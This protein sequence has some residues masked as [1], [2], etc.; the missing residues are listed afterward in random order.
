MTPNLT[1]PDADAI[2]HIAF[3]QFVTL[4]DPDAVVAHLRE[5][6]QPL[7]GSILVAAE[8]ING[9][10]AGTVPAL[11][12]FEQALQHDPR[13]QGKF[14]GIT[15]KRSACATKPFW[16]VRVHRKAEIVAFGVEGVTGVNADADSGARPP[17]H[18][19]PQAWRELIA[20]DDVVVIDNRNSFEFRLG[21]FKSALDP[22]VDTF[23]DFPDYIK[24]HAPHW[25]ATGKRVA[26]YCT[27]GI[28]CEKTS[29]W[30]QD[31]GLDVVQ[32]DGGILNYFQAMPDADKDW[33]GECFV[34]DNRIALD[35]TLHETATTAEDVYQGD[36]ADEW[37]LQRARRLD[38]AG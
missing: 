16:K 30:M 7:T 13:L 25:Q 1:Q 23:R 24:A 12:A 28:R 14:A 38:S 10:L 35:T 2:F 4:E 5:L 3:Y 34:F 19:S 27:G 26:M 6:V 21:H 36:P 29:R 31:L 15:F 37:R 11:H 32:L 8:G 18:V 17:T 9:V 20:R 22:K 33:E